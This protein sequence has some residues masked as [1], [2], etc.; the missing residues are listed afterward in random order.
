[1]H[2]GCIFVLNADDDMDQTSSYQHYEVVYG[3]FSTIADVLILLVPILLFVQLHVA[4]EQKNILV[5][6]FDMGIFVIMVAVLN[7]IY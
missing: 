7:K 1:M 4:F 6:L 2:Y 5:V 3:C